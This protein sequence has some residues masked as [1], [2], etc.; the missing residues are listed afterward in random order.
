MAHGW[1]SKACDGLAGPRE[2]DVPEPHGCWSLH[3]WKWQEVTSGM[4]RG[5]AGVAA[6]HEP[7]T[8]RRPEAYLHVELSP[9]G[10]GLHH[11]VHHTDQGFALA[12]LRQT[13]KES[14]EVSGDVLGCHQSSG[15]ARSTSP[16]GIG[17]QD[18]TSKRCP[19]GLSHMGMAAPGCCCSGLCTEEHPGL[20]ARPENFV[21]GKTQIKPSQLRA[22]RQQTAHTDTSLHRDAPGCNAQCGPSRRTDGPHSSC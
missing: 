21:E 3:E 16:Q 17:L 7:C 20:V 5:A 13:G 2:R 6:M 14:S 22:G 18:A 19:R 9:R 11:P 15:A 12:H 4:E 8:A 10:G 1:I